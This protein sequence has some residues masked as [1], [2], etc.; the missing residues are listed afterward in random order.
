MTTLTTL[1]KTFHGAQLKQLTELLQNQFEDLDVELKVLGN[2][3]NKWVQVSVEGEDEAVA[4][5]FIR[6]ELGICPVSLEAIEDGSVLRGYVSKVDGERLQVD[7]GVFEPKIILAS[8][9]LEVLQTQLLA[10]KVVGLKKIAD[11]YAVSEGL[12]LS[13]KVI[14]KTSDGLLA[15]LADSQVE[16]FQTWQNSLLDRLIVLRASKELVTTTLERTHLDRDVID[17]E[18]LGMF[19]FALVCKLGT[20]AAGLIPRV[21]RYMRYGV[22]V[23]FSSKRLT[24]FLCEQ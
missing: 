12:I 22:F 24:T 21:G 18:T 11:A 7:V 5:S 10:G 8:V 4:T 17:V 19:E 13:V 9:P 23:V 2:T 20:D 6:R 14:A 3:P 15:E 16:K 1:V